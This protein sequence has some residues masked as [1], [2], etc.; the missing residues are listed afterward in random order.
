MSI[1]EEES[2]ADGVTMELEMEWD[3]NPTIALDV[4]THVGVVIPVK[5]N[6]QRQG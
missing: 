5:V 2:G 4:K 1:I 6:N 3:G